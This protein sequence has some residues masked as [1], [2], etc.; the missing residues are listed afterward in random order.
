MLQETTETNPSI[1]K[2]EMLYLIKG[3]Y[4]VELTFRKIGYRQTQKCWLGCKVAQLLNGS[5]LPEIYIRPLLCNILNLAQQWP[6]G[7]VFLFEKCKHPTYS[8]QAYVDTINKMLARFGL[9]DTQGNIIPFVTTMLFAM[10]EAV[11]VHGVDPTKCT[12]VFNPTKGPTALSV[13]GYKNPF[14]KE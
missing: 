8:C 13:V 3:N 14:T 5:S 7:I 11:T 6:E 10:L 1:A 12:A 4:F 9:V 2:I